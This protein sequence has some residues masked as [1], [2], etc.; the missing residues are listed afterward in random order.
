MWLG[1]GV[2]L[3]SLF[4]VGGCESASQDR[5][6]IASANT[7]VITPKIVWPAAST[8]DDRAFAA[9]GAGSKEDDSRVRALLARSPVVVL[10]PTNVTFKRPTF[11]VGPEYYALTGHVDGATIAIQGKRAAHRYDDIAP[12]P[13]DHALRGG[14]GFVSVNEGIR[15]SS[16][17]ENG[18]AYSVDVEC[19]EATDERCSSEA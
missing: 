13:G 1:R 6:V 17:I 14:R 3:L 15:T 10:A 5:E 2:V 4:V 9:L 16:W 11:V 8:R 19:S 18:A 12:I 7:N